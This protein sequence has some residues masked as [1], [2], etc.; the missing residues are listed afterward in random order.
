[1]YFL[2]SILICPILFL[3]K[4]MYLFVLLFDVD[5]TVILTTHYMDEADLLGD[6]IAI[7]ANGKVQCCGSSV[8]LKNRYGSGYHLTIELQSHSRKL[9]PTTQVNLLEVI[10]YFY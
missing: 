3:F 1:M 5:R 4:V 6:R 10:T 2:L 9:P 7:I 8:Y